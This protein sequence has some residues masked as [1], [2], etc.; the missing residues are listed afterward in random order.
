[1]AHLTR[2]QLTV[3][4]APQNALKHFNKLTRM[5]QK[6]EVNSLNMLHKIHNKAVKAAVCG[7]RWRMRNMLVRAAD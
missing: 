6:S 5:L 7:V 3:K 4:I 2:K 1:L